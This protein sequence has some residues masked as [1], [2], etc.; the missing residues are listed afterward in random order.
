MPTA[1]SA[2]DHDTKNFT[3]AGG[4]LVVKCKCGRSEEAT[5]DTYDAVRR[6]HVDSFA[7]SDPALSR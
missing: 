3:T 7:S 2:G 6:A 5:Y 1:W 4:T